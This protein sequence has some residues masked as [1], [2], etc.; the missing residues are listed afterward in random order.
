MLTMTVLS[1]AFALKIAR[2]F[3]LQETPLATRAL[4]TWP[5]V[6]STLTL[7]FITMRPVAAGHVTLVA[8][9]EATLFTY[10]ERK[11]NMSLLIRQIRCMDKI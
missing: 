9:P 8:I 5:T 3:G 2:V 11:V 6:Q 7:S 10:F 4:S 1:K